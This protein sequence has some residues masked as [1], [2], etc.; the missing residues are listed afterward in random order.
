MLRPGGSFILVTSSSKHFQLQDKMAQAEGVLW[1]LTNKEC[2]TKHGIKYVVH[3]CVK[4]VAPPMSDLQ[5]F[6]LDTY[7]KL[8]LR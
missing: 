7:K 3:H 2:Y 6:S 4:K 5:R 1:E 8:G